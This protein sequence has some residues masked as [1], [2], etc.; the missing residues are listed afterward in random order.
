V[1]DVEPIGKW[2]SAEILLSATEKWLD[3]YHKASGQR[4]AFLHADVGWG[5]DWVGI[6]TELMKFAR[7]KGVRFGM[8]YNGEDLA[9]SD[10]EWANEAISHF[11]TFERGGRQPDDVIFQSWVS[12]PKHILPESEGNSMS[13]IVRRYL[14]DHKSTN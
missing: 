6:T 2:A 10:S 4:L 5:T 11:E 3:A 13:G 9:H 14:D 1:G 8:I 7:Q 12:H